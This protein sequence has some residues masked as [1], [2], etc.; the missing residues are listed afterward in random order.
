MQFFTVLKGPRFNQAPH[1]VLAKRKRSALF[2]K[3]WLRAEK[4]FKK[5]KEKKWSAFNLGRQGVNKV[6]GQIFVFI[7]LPGESG[8]RD[9][10][11]V[12][13][14]RRGPDREPGRKKRPKIPVAPLKSVDHKDPVC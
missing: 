12:S 3:N 11:S 6:P 7:K 8:M 14:E 2:K 9:A 1:Y 10:A 13:E 4:R 5:K